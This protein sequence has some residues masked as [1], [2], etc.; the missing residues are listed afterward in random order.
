MMAHKFDFVK[1]IQFAHKKNIIEIKANE[2]LSIKEAA[3][4]FIIRPNTVYKWGKKIK[5]K[6]Q[7]KQRVSKI[8]MNPNY[9]QENIASSIFS[10]LQ[11]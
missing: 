3:R 8:Y 5:P 1:N 4:R 10:L 9:G 2:K 6:K 11:R 7:R